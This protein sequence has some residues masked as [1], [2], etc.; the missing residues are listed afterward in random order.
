MAERDFSLI[1]NVMACPSVLP[2]TSDNSHVK[3]FMQ[4]NF[5]ILKSIFNLKNIPHQKPSDF[6]FK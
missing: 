5:E 2:E 6:L 4:T 1:K 3:I